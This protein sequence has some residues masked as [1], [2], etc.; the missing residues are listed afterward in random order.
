MGEHL[1]SY[2]NQYVEEIGANFIGGLYLEENVQNL[3]HAVVNRR[4]LNNGHLAKSNALLL[5]TQI[6][7]STHRGT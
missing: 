7:G 6:L 5:V 3:A 2:G 1:V 4:L